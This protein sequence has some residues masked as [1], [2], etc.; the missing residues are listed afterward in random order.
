M[1]SS[2]QGHRRTGWSRGGMRTAIAVIGAGVL[3]LSAAA[4]ASGSSSKGYG[5]PLGKYKT[6]NLVSDQAGKADIRDP[7]LVNAWGLAFGTNPKTPGWVADNGA[8][9]STLYTGDNGTT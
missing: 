9:V 5:S 1:R 6:H 4:L 2:E 7:D 3:A 8:D